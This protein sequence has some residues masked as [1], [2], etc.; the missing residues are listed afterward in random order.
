MKIENG[1]H[2]YGKSDQMPALPVGLS[3]DFPVISKFGFK[4][5]H[6]NGRSYWEVGSEADYRRCEAR[7]LA[8]D[9]KDVSVLRECG[10]IGGQCAGSC[11]DGWCHNVVDDS[12]MY[13]YCGCSKHV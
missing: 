8:I 10:S 1:L 11:T 9:P 7:R 13:F 4:I 2:V 3:Y 6:L 5:V 12:T